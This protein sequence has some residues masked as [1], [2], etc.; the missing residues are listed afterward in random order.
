MDDPVFGMMLD[1]ISLNRAQTA[2]H[3]AFSIAIVGGRRGGPVIAGVWTFRTELAARE[4]T[5]PPFLTG[6]VVDNTIIV[7]PKVNKNVLRL[8]WSIEC[9][10][11]AVSF[12][13]W[14]IPNTIMK[15][16]YLVVA[17]D[18][19]WHPNVI[20]AGHTLTP[21]EYLTP[22][23][24]EEAQLRVRTPQQWAYEKSTK[25]AMLHITRPFELIMHGVPRF[26]ITSEDVHFLKQIGHTYIPIWA[27]THRL[28]DIQVTHDYW[29]RQ[30]HSRCP[31]R[32][33]DVVITIICCARRQGCCVDAI[34]LILPFLEI[35]E[36]PLLQVLT[37]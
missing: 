36:S 9:G 26:Q 13:H 4:A 32:V 25:P 6:K 24:E 29:T 16:Q 30:I 33:K 12:E 28:V 5:I 1:H 18:S 35:Q 20:R 21:V 23:Q 17:L 2:T 8:P 14:P 31:K 3:R 37:T 22:E 7:R 27:N 19:D 11:C 15:S 10:R 34:M